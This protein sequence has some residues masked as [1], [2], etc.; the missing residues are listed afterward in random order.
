M[1][2]L[3]APDYTTVPMWV[4]VKLMAQLLISKQKLSPNYYQ[5][6]I[7][8]NYLPHYSVVYWYS[9]YSEATQSRGDAH[10]VGMSGQKAHWN[11]KC[12]VVLWRHRAVVDVCWYLQ[13]GEYS[14]YNAKDLCRPQYQLSAL[15]GKTWTDYCL[16]PRRRWLLLYIWSN[17]RIYTMGTHLWLLH[18]LLFCKQ[19]LSMRLPLRM[20]FR[21][22][23]SLG[24]TISN[25]HE[26]LHQNYSKVWQ[27]SLEYLA[28]IK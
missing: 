8:C 20:G 6:R 27:F 24:S 5:S 3:W 14:P 19:K 11:M 22:P 2:S 7:H 9:A 28:N 4:S 16:K 18:P 1:T 21:R 26:L 10:M 12:A 17:N 25:L 15:L 13:T 23:G